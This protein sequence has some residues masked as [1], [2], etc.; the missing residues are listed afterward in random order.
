[1]KMLLAAVILAA[2]TPMA[3][4]QYGG[5]GT[6]YGGYGTGSNSQSHSVGGYTTNRG[7]YIQ[8]HTSTNPNSTQYDNYGTRG[9]YNPNTGSYGTRN[10]RY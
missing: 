10:P 6:G 9:N 3:F 2:G 8:P 1:M 4:A 7:T 5:Y